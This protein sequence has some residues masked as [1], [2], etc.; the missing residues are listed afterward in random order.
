MEIE[1][2]PCN[3]A[4]RFI[5]HRLGNRYCFEKT[6]FLRISP[7]KQQYFRMWILGLQFLID[8]KNRVWKSHASV[9]LSKK[10]ALINMLMINHVFLHC[11]QLNMGALL[12]CPCLFCPSDNVQRSWLADAPRCVHFSTVIS[13]SCIT[14]QISVGKCA[15]PG[16]SAHWERQTSFKIVT[17]TK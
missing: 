11:I 5:N 1:K 8:S 6:L 9:P 7:R 2:S 13:P 12:L 17:W 3:N 10:F 15:H 14:K 4:W 16:A